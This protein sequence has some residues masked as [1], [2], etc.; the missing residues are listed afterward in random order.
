MGFLMTLPRQCG[1]VEMLSWPVT[2][3]IILNKSNY[4]KTRILAQNSYQVLYSN[5]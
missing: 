3:A 1:E 5:C 4:N 2:C